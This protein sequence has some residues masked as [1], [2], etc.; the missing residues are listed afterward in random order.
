MVFLSIKC[1]KEREGRGNRVF[2]AELC[3]TGKDGVVSAR[4]LFG[5]LDTQLHAN[6]YFTETVAH[7]T[8]GL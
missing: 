3:A 8:S 2:I 4:G 6:S 5:K 7:Q 1:R